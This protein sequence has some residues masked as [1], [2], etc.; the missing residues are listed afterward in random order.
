VAEALAAPL[1]DLRG[2]RVVAAALLSNLVSVGC[3]LSLF[4]LFLEPVSSELGIGK[5]AAGFGHFLGQITGALGALVVG[6]WVL[7]R[8]VRPV[9]L[10]GALCV[11]L[12]LLAMSR[13]ES[14]WQAGL[15]FV[16]LL[17]VGTVLTGPVST[18]TLV[19]N[20]Y[21]ASRGR[22]LGI[23]AAGTTFGGALLPP[24]AAALLERFGWRDALALLGA[25]TG[26]LLLP[27][28]WAWVTDRPEQQ[29]HLTPPLERGAPLALGPALRDPRVWVMAG[30]L[31]FGFAGGLV[32]V[33]FTVPY[34]KA[35]GFS[36]QTGAWVMSV[37]AL[38][39]AFGKVVF[40]AL[41]DH[42]DRRWLLGGM[43]VASA[44]LLELFLHARTSFEF[45]LI[46]GMV[47][48]ISA[49]LL[50]LVQV[51]IGAVFGRDAFA[52]VMGLLS[53]LRLPLQLLAAPLFGLLLDATDS[54]YAL[55]FRV[56]VGFFLLAALLLPLLRVPHPRDAVA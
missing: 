48:F 11:V 33:L 51:V 47:G 17:G 28:L 50:P 36:L 10:G 29:P 41:S 7:S 3:G 37:R 5:A 12:G 34:A 46:A 23:A 25:G 20:W 13:V 54:D 15:V 53:F 39:G 4:G 19:T 40:G 21:V 6:W 49:P 55:A 9:L 22:A 24:I 31:G 16:A 35:V 44:L 43:L 18:A 45:A 14:G 8:W 42:V 2:P 56:Y 30:I 32:M 27:L 1:A 52:Q 26:A 38:S